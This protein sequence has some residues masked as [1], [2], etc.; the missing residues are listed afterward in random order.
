M[1]NKGEWK[2][3]EP[4]HASTTNI[5]VRNSFFIAAMSKIPAWAQTYQILEKRA[6]ECVMGMWNRINCIRG[7]FLSRL[8]LF[9]RRSATTDGY[10]S[11]L[12]HFGLQ[13]F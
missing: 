8:G 7:F 2:L 3:D 11:F 1:Q 9:Q 4:L 5:F 13:N 10:L 6:I 12:R